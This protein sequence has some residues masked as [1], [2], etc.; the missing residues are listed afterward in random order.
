RPSLAEP[1]QNTIHRLLGNERQFGWVH[2][3]PFEPA[4]AVGYDDERAAIGIRRRT[5]AVEYRCVW[6]G[7]EYRAQP[8][9]Y[10]VGGLTLR[11][12]VG[13]G[14]GGPGPRPPRPRPRPGPSPGSP[15]NGPPRRPKRRWSRSSSSR[16]AGVRTATISD[17]AESVTARRRCSTESVRGRVRSMMA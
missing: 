9:A 11:W 10:A 3:L 12:R 6:R 5:I 15:P 7:R 14:G 1:V 13:P 4:L 16:C 2:Q 17:C 8:G